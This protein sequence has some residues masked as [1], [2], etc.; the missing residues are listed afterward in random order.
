MKEFAPDEHLMKN[1][2]ANL[3]YWWTVQLDDYSDRYISVLVG[4]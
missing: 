3:T 4:G 2:L 1:V